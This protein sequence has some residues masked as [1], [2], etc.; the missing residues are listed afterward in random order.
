MICELLFPS[1]ILA[2]KLNRKSLV[3]VLEMEIYIYDISNMR[4]LHVIETSPNP[5]GVLY[6]PLFPRESSLNIFLGSYLRSIAIS[7]QLILGIS[8]PCT[9]THITA[10][11]RRQSHLLS[12]ILLCFRFRLCLIFLNLPSPS[13]RRRPPLLHTLPNRIQ[14]H[15]RAQIP[16]RLPRAQLDRYPPRYILRKGDSDPGMECARRGEVVSVPSGDKGGEDMVDEF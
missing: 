12:R 10:D 9:L 4:L 2:V 16:A 7:R 8:L 6:Y 3:I 15:P 13:V 11:Q 1:S 14:C 5:E